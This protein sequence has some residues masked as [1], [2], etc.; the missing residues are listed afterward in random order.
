MIELQ[1]RIY[2]LTDMSG[3]WGQW[4]QA[5]KKTMGFIFEVDVVNL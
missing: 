3:T 5:L 1:V 2:Q 4:K